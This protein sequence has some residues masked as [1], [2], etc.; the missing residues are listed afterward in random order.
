MKNFSARF[1]LSMMSAAIAVFAAI[2]P[3]RSSA[4]L[5]LIPDQ[6]MRDHMNSL[7]PGC[8]DANGYLDP[9]FPGVQQIDTLSISP[10]DVVGLLVDLDLSF[11]GVLGGVDQLYVSD[12]DGGTLGFPPN[13]KDLRLSGM[14][15][16]PDSIAP[17]PYGLRDLTLFQMYGLDTLVLPPSLRTLRIDECTP[18][19]LQFPD[20]LES[21]LLHDGGYDTL[22]PL[23]P[24]L[25]D[26]SIG[27]PDLSTWPAWPAGLHS[28]WL[29]NNTGAIA[30]PTWIPDLPEGLR[31]FGFEGEG[32]TCLPELP[33]SLWHLMISCSTLL[34]AP[35]QPLSLAADSVVWAVNGSPI[36]FSVCSP[37]TSLCP[38]D[39][40]MISGRIY[41]DANGNGVQ[42]MGETALTGSTITAAPWPW[43]HPLDTNGDYALGVLPGTYTVVPDPVVPYVQSIQPA[44]HTAVFSGAGQSDNGNDFGVQLIPNIQ[45]WQVDLVAW[46]SRPGFN[47][48]LV[49]I[50]RNNGT[51]VL[52]GTLQ[53]TFDPLFMYMG[54]YHLSPTTV[55]ANVLTYDVLNV[56]V[57]GVAKCGI[58]LHADALV[59]LGTPYSHTA[60]MDPLATDQVAA[61]NT[62]TLSDS[63]VGSYDPNDKAVE[64]TQLTPAQVAAGERVEYTIRFQN[65]G[66]YLA[67]RVVIT[68]TLSS[69]LQWN[70]MQLI[71]ASHEHT[72]HI[73]GGV[74]HVV[75]DN[76]MLPDSTSDE[77][78][79]HGFVKFSMKPVSTLMLG[80]SV[81]NIANIFFDF[82]EPVITNAAVFEVN[83]NVGVAEAQQNGLHLYPN[84]AGDELTIVANAATANMP[85]EVVD[86]T[87]RI[88]L[89][90]STSVPNTRVD[91]GS[92]KPGCYKVRVGTLSTARFVKR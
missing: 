9:A 41:S 83:N 15:G 52:S 75:F 25:K 17:F 82:N 33:D 30:T 68:D 8:V 89:R 34:C 29:E 46:P 53:L 79:S 45:D 44:S 48:G 55:V 11:L 63:I 56:P 50:V 31:Y 10:F 76:I 35:N 61:D 92:L 36:A 70:T 18:P 37:L 47:N 49:A 21:L 28:L 43:N 19:L 38:G 32:P 91:V 13:L 14:F 77:S 62:M 57:G 71:A 51:E 81:A 80:E 66:T 26:C 86:V 4:Q 12:C 74:L 87:G 69:D 22:P 1:G 58:I 5:T 7:V 27:L 64:P 73:L 72:W 88:V 84:P 40:S 60:V 42:D 2:T 90:S 59:A 24:T 85:L 54:S 3:T 23:P 78:G 20:S 6:V 67:E 16:W 65:T 39:G